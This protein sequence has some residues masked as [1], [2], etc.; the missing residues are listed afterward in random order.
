MKAL[1]LRT[2]LVGAFAAASLAL[3]G[4]GGGFS[5]SDKGSCANDVAPTQAAIDACQKQ[6]D[7]ACGSQAKDLG[8]CSK[9]NATC[10]AD[11]HTTTDA[12]KCSTQLAAV[13][14]CCTSNPDAC[15]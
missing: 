2:I 9:D 12:S 6:L 14:S 13:I 10:D 4:C 11:G 5:C 1:N 8:S 3:A 15:Q 7:G